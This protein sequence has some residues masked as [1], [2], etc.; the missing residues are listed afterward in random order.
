MEGML[1]MNQ[2]EENRIGVISSLEKNELTVEEAAGVMKISTRQVYRI[3]KR[4]KREGTKG[5]IHKINSV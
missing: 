3:I 5:I 1:T 2:K 4:I